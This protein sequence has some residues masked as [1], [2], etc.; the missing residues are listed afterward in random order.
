MTQDRTLSRQGLDQIPEIPSGSCLGMQAPL[1][2]AEDLCHPCPRII[3]GL[4]KGSKCF[5]NDDGALG[6][7]TRKPVS[8]LVLT[9]QVTLKSN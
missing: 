1:E 7:E 2:R 8:S 4:V 6:L 3:L 5:A 9:N